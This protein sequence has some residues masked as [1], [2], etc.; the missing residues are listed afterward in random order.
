[1]RVL[2]LNREMQECQKFECAVF[3]LRFVAVLCCT[4]PAGRVAL[5][6][7]SLNYSIKTRQLYQFLKCLHVVPKK[8][9]WG[10]MCPSYTWTPRHD[11]EL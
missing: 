3:S 1:M 11:I 6:R 10:L 8:W 2:F 7:W 4:Y 5:M 9:N